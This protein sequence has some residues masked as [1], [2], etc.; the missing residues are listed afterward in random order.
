M[1]NSNKHY[2]QLLL[3]FLCYNILFFNFIEV[4]LIYSVVLI[5]AVQ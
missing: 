5:S 4:S 2:L 3:N 1:F